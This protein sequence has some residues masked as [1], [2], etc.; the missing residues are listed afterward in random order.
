M[1]L[2]L[3]KE[4]KI[5]LASQSP[6]RQVLL[7]EAGIEYDLAPKI[8][9]DESYNKKLKEEKIPLF[10]S[11][12]KADAY[13]SSLSEKN[14]I[15]ITADTIVWQN[16]SMLGKPTSERDAFKIIKHLS[17]DKHDVFTG[18]TLTS[19]EK[20]VSFYSKSSV[21]FDKLSKDE[22]KYYIEKY[23]PFDK[24]GAY[25]IQEWIGYIGIK[26]IKGSF[27]NVMGLPV[28]QLYVELKKFVDFKD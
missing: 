7:K 17:N 9:V 1:F 16:K 26:K 11:E 27:Y 19:L 24:A 8:D 20:Q 4:Y 23:K 15:L 18:V 28:H 3:L 14:Q 13:K 22:I 21:Y 10:L 6:R 2:D 12:L 5:I 25:G